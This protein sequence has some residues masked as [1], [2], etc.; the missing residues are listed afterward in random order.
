MKLHNLLLTAALIFAAGTV[1][2]K[3]DKDKDKDKD[4]NKPKD[5]S[6]FLSVN[7]EEGMN[8]I[9][10]A[11]FRMDQGWNYT[12]V[13]YKIVDNNLVKVQDLADMSANANNRPNLIASGKANVKEAVATIEDL[14]N[15]VR[16]G[17]NT[18]A[19]NIYQF[20]VEIPEEVTVL[21]IVGGNGQGGTEESIHVGTATDKD[22][23]WTIVENKIVYFGK[24]NW[25]GK[26]NNGAMFLIGGEK[27]DKFGAPLPA[28]VVTLLIALGFGAALVMYRNRKQVKA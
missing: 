6:E 17:L 8:T 21:G 3:N 9:N 2:A 13:G 14:P 23:F 18:H 1:S 7:R 4:K 5:Y 28:P 10:I 20:S 24:S 26:Y 19:Q 25:I 11:V 27:M 12:L 22:N 16:K 15:D